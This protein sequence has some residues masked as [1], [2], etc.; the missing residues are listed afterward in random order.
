MTAATHGFAIEA[1]QSLAFARLSG[2]FNPL[3][4]DPVAARR[5]QFGG[6]VCHGVHLVLKS[7]DQAVAAGLVDLLRVQGVQVVFQSPALTGQ[8][9]DLVLT[10]QGSRWRMQGLREGRV[11]FSVLLPMGD[12]EPLVPAPAASAV[13][14]G[15]MPMDR[16]FEVALAG[17]AAGA[18]GPALAGTL[19][20]GMDAALFADLFPALAAA[21]KAPLLAAEL[22]ATTRVV[23]ME[24]PG[25]HSVYCELKL[26]RAPS[27]DGG[28]GLHWAVN[29]ADAR[30]RKV[31]IGV[32][33]QAWAGTLDAIFRDAPVLQASLAD[34]AQH[35]GAQ[36]FAGQRALV[37]GGSRG[38]GE[39]VV[40]LLLAGGAE[41]TL[42]Y[43]SGQAEAQAI[44]GQAQAAGRTCHTLQLD[45]T[46]LPDTA[47]LATLAAGRFTHLYYFATPAIAKGQP[48]QWSEALFE[49]FQQFYVRGFM[50]LGLSLV[51]TQAAGAV[52]LRVLVPSSVFIDQPVRG[53]AEYG[54]AKAAGEAAAAHLALT[55][56]A[57][58]LMPRL[59]RL[60]TDQNSDPAD[61]DVQDPVPVMLQVLHDLDVLGAAA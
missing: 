19:P 44:Q 56:K 35:V 33:G 3:H 36:R 45:V 12:A 48:Q 4:V 17:P 41:V 28:T 10:D 38:L 20:T 53:F 30:F 24:C 42:T 54:A 37:V 9:V 51:A 21:A 25:L 6:T 7:L 5:L 59:P 23:G 58:V 40:K 57:R 60:R 32:Q 1:A 55:G 47:G 61:P 27:T 16:S 15:A 18:P 46:R 14:P 2:D 11:L 49:R 13:E 31:R 22:L 34:M 50:Q 52:P 39:V 43:A 8:W 26:A 29:K